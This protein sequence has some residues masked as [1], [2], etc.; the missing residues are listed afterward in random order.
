MAVILYSGVPGSGKSLNVTRK[1]ML[2]LWSGRDVIANFPIKFT[3]REIRKGFDKRFFYVPEDRITVKNLAR[4]ANYRGYLKKK[5]E[6]QCLVVIDEAGIRF[7]VK[8]D[9][10]EKQ[11]MEDFFNDDKIAEV[12]I[13]GKKD[14]MQWVKFFSQHRKFG[15]DFILI[16]QADR[17]LDRQIRAMVEIEYKHRKASSM[18]WWFKLFP[19]K[20]FV[21][22]EM[23]YGLNLKTDV[24]F[25][26]Y[27]RSL[28]DRY[29]SMKLFDGY[30]IET[31]KGITDIYAIFKP[32]E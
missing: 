6:S 1:I 18:Y 8:T 5:K 10:E 25:F 12:K 24:Q 31:E 14:R 29:D 21:S 19:W 3:K 4:F 28:G 11:A 15:F 9:K 22:V 20:I 30:E 32:E 2:A 13:Y 26:V 23:Y 17:M 16:A 7:N 27:K